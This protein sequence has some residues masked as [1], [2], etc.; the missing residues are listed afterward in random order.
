[1]LKAKWMA[2]GSSSLAQKGHSL[3]RVLNL[4]LIEILTSE[5]FK[6]IRCATLDT[7]TIWPTLTR[8]SKKTK[9]NKVILNTGKFVAA[10]LGS[11]GLIQKD[12][13]N[14]FL[15]NFNGLNL[16]VAKD[17]IKPFETGRMI[18]IKEKQGKQFEV[19]VN[20]R[21]T[22]SE[23]AALWTGLDWTLRDCVLAAKIGYKPSTI[24]A[25]RKKLGKP[26]ATS[27]TQNWYIKRKQ[28]ETWDWS[29]SN[30]ELSKTHGTTFQNISQI[31]ARYEF[32]AHEEKIEKT[33]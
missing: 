33:T 14:S 29:Q 12:F 26:K 22:N 17:D 31:R 7:V 19:A 13:G 20:P 32:P 8:V 9:Q 2:C 23:K 30:R 21:K 5:I 28:Y 18:K 15:V 1:L 27:H 16:T 4:H 10:P 25:M 11:V 24:C 3:S 6:N